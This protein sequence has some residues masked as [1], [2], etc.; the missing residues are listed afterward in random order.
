[1]NADEFKYVPDETIEKESATS[2]VLYRP[3]S[4]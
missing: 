3:R 1:M 2:D 4:S